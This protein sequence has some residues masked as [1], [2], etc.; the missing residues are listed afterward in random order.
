M[1]VDPRSANRILAISRTWECQGATPRESIET[2]HFRSDCSSKIDNLWL[3]VRTLDRLVWP[4]SQS[5]S[6][7]YGTLNWRAASQTERIC[8]FWIASIANKT[9]PSCSVDFLA[10]WERIGGIVGGWREWV[11]DAISMGWS[12]RLCDLWVTLLL[13]GK[14]IPY[15]SC[16][17]PSA[18]RLPQY[19]A[20]VGGL[21]HLSCTKGLALYQ[22][23]IF[24]HITTFRVGLNL[25]II[26]APTI[27]HYANYILMFPYNARMARFSAIPP[28]FNLKPRTV[29]PPRLN[30]YHRLLSRLYKPLVL[31][32]LL[33]QT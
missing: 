30:K 15:I 7:V 31:L 1:G 24:P 18:D 25:L 33:R 19:Q 23:S 8:F 21:I 14:K 3:L 28:R 5:D 27:A 10:F 29:G 2:T 17:R 26:I 20:Q 12:A 9:L 4:R 32:H 6:V 13:S 22:S 16:A 11:R